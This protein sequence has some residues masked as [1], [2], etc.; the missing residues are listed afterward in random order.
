MKRIFI[1]LSCILVFLTVET[2]A[3]K[4]YHSSGW[5]FIFAGADVGFNGTDVKNKVR[6]TLFFHTQQHMNIDLTRHI[7]LFTGVGIRNIGFIVNDLYQNV[8][9]P[10]VG[11]TDPNWNKSTKIIRRSYSLGFP[12]AF[13]LG[14]MEKDFFMF[15]GGEYEWMF[16]YRQRMFLEDN[17]TSYGEWFS[18]R[19][20]PWVPS[21]FAGIQF[22]VG[23]R[24]VVKYYMS[25]FL[26]TSFT[27]RDFGRDVDYSLFDST[28]MWYFSFAF[29]FS[30]KH[31]DRLMDKSDFV[32]S[33]HIH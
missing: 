15:A 7:G 31:F 26:N 23:I 29:Y 28:R 22:P 30:K 19:V 13:K 8:G 12:L 2:R 27:G 17:E 18:K 5:E 25:D 33:A 9:F 10:D 14:D 3:Q 32:K 16:H 20:N 11:I 4:I 24:L 21:L 6:F 1:T